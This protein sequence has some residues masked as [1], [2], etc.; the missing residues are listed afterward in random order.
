MESSSFNF[1]GDDNILFSNNYATRG[2]P[3]S[4]NSSGNSSV[5]Q[6]KEMKTRMLNDWDLTELQI[7]WDYICGGRGE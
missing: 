5:R 6:L 7:N 1:S 3:D 2:I 4:N